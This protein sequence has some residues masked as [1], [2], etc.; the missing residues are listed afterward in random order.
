MVA[1]LEH[2]LD[3][4]TQKLG[5]EIEFRYE[6]FYAGVARDGHSIHLKS[7]S[8]ARE[9]RINKSE[10]EHL[11]PVFSV[12]GTDGLFEAIESRPICI[13]QPLD[14]CLMAGSLYCRPGRLHTGPF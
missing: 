1:D 3:F 11:D 8:L 10:N 4:Y 5:V 12:E 6:D 2:S 14:R 13:M 7:G 9:E